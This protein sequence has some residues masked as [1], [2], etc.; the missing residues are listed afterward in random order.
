MD[1]T[2]LKEYQKK[3]ILIDYYLDSLLPKPEPITYSDISAAY[4]QM[5][6]KFFVVLAEIKYQLVDI[7]PAWLQVKD[8]NQGRPEYAEKL[9]V[10][11]IQ[12]LKADKDFLE[13]AKEYR[14]PGV[15]FRIPPKP[16]PPESLVE[17]Y[18]VIATE[19]DKLE[20]GDISGPIETIDKNQQKHILIIKLEDKRSKGYKPLEKVQRQVEA[21]IISDRRKQAEK[22][23]LSGFRQQAE[24]EL[25]DEFTELC[26]QKIYDTRNELKTG[27]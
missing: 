10:E 6:E 21:K 15:T 18:D 13:L 5:K 25:N 14:T 19:A 2:E 23:I 27:N 3:I 11:L 16:V 22:L 8:P 26:M 24:N 4:N 1:W 12:Q 9:A 17:P 20:S 7:E